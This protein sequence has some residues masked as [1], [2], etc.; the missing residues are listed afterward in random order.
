MICVENWD[1]GDLFSLALLPLVEAFQ[2]AG[3][4]E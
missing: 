1:S 3:A 4:S 2:S